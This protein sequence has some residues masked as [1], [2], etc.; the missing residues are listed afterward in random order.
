MLLLDY[1]EIAE[2]FLCYNDVPPTKTDRLFYVY[3]GERLAYLTED[4]PSTA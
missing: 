4:A 1:L 3:V 2:D